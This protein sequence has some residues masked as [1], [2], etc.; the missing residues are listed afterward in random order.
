MPLLRGA[1]VR[2]LIL[3]LSS[4]LLTS[5]CAVR[6]MARWNSAFPN[7]FFGVVLTKHSL[8][9]AFALWSEIATT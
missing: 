7:A 4:L 2:G 8:H 5:Q 3:G 1:L 9:R 6:R